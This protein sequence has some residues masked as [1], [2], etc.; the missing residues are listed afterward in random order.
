M[1]ERAINGHMVRHR[2]SFIR[3]IAP[4]NNRIDTRTHL[5]SLEIYNDIERDDPNRTEPGN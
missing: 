2:R 3:P 5:Q 1:T 4:K